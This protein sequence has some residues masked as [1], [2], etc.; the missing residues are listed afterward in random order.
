MSLHDFWG[1]VAAKAQETQ[2]TSVVLGTIGWDNAESPFDLGSEENDGFTLIRVQLFAGRD[3]S[4]DRDT[5]G[6]AQGYRLLCTVADHVQ[7]FGPPRKGDRCYVLLPAG[8]EQTPGAGLV[9]AIVSRAPTTQYGANRG[10]IDLGADRDFVI[11]ARSVTLTTHDNKQISLSPEGGV[12]IFDETGG[13]IQ[14]KSGAV[15]SVATKYNLVVQSSGTVKAVMKMTD[16]EASMLGGDCML[17]MKSGQCTVNGGKFVA[18]TTLCLIGI[19]AT[20]ANFAITTVP[21]GSPGPST[22]VW[23][24]P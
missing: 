14:F 1:T 21:P 12:Q 13:G 18:N 3:Q 6:S 19:G 9:V 24:A 5:S 23:I 10:K 7:M 17:K 11:K 22:K 16:S 4:K 2:A 8:H 20:A 15:Y